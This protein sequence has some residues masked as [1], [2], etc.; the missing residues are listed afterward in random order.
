MK[1]IVTDLNGF[2]I[3]VTD[4][5]GAIEQTELMK[6]F[7]HDPPKVFDEQ[8]KLYWNDLYNKLLELKEKQFGQLT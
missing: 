7:R 6:E 8:R 4:L 2:E 5:A 3:E 1:T